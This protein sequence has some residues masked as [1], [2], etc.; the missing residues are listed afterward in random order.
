MRERLPETRTGVTHKAVIYSTP[1]VCEHCGKPRDTG[2]VKF[3]L[4][5]NVFPDGRPGEVF[6]SADQSGGTLD[7]FAEAWGTAISMLLQHGMSLDELERKFAFQQFEPS[8]RTECKE[9]GLARSIVDYVI[10]WMRLENERLASRSLADADREKE[11][12]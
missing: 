2:R 3:F 8:G 10:R 7:G 11:M 4:T 12:A 9:I 1:E 6:V 5:M